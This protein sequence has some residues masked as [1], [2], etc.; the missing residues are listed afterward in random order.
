MS[1]VNQDIL[2]NALLGDTNL[3][4]VVVKAED[5]PQEGGIDFSK[6]FFEPKPGNS[7]LIKFLPN[8][9]GTREPIVHRKVYKSLP[10]PTRKGKTF[11][12]TSAGVA[13]K[14][15]VLQLFFDLNNLKKNGDPVATQKI[16]EFM[17][18]TNQGC[19][20]IQ[21]LSSPVKEEVGIVRM[22]S[23]STFGPNATVANLLNKKISPTKE[24]IEQGFEKEDVFNIFESSV[25]SLVC[26]KAV[27][28]NRE[29]RDY[30][31]SD[32][33]PKKRGAIAILEDGSQRAFK[34]SDKE[35]IG[36]GDEE[37]LKYFNAFA[38]V[39]QSPD[40]SIHNYFAYKEVGNP[41]N[42]KETED[43]LK[44][45]HEKVDEIVP[46]IESKSVAEIK[47]YGKAVPASEGG[48]DGKSKIIGGG[49]ADDILKQS[50]PTELGGSVLNQAAN[51]SAPSPAAAP[52]ANA[53]ESDVDKI[54]NS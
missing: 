28:N 16:D 4:N 9:E 44:A 53:G 54:L 32:W 35:L 42:T 39:L 52:S 29:G 21:V 7:Y 17:G 14:C 30:S 20:K 25:M 22:M 6:H 50:A 24:Q 10:D 2:K 40:Y 5:L 11:Q 34:A 37:V 13:S 27:Y 43:Y 47:N 46:I 36:K 15:K 1:E 41:L 8:L 38:A 45:V 3:E 19:A 51:Q 33:A 49:N 48:A 23:F 18:C 31:K 26:E 12:F